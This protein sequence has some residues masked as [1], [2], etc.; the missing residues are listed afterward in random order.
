[1]LKITT[2]SQGPSGCIL[3]LEGKLL[4]PWIDELTQACRM[5]REETSQLVLDLSAVSFLDSHGRAALRDMIRE[6]VAV[7]MC[8]PLVAELLKESLS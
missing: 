6:G 7:Q 8:S 5:A 3:K 2:I 4:E 1:M